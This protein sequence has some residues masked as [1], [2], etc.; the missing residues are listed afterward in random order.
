MTV[1]AI[2]FW[3]AIALLVYTQVGYALLLALLAALVG[4]RQRRDRRDPAGRRAAAGH[5]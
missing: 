2:V 5:G 1:V 4:S 3:V